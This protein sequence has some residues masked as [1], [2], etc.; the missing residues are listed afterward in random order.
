MSEMG[1]TPIRRIVT[2]FYGFT[3]Q[4]SLSLLC[5]PTEHATV[6]VRSVGLPLD[7]LLS[8]STVCRRNITNDQY[9]LKQQKQPPRKRDSSAKP[10]VS[11]FGVAP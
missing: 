10:Q 7:K 8:N 2:P 4:P 9:V 5:P 1:W 11:C 6:Y 3:L